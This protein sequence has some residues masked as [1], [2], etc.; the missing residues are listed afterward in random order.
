MSS[1]QHLYTTRLRIE[2]LRQSHATVVFPAQQDPSIYQYIPENALSLEEL[3]R[4]YDFLEKAT[5]PDGTEHW[6]NWIVFLKDTDIVIGTFQATIPADGDASIAYIVFPAFWKRGYATEI[7]NHMLSHIFK[8]YNPST[9][10]AEIDTRNLASLQL[11]QR[12]GF[13]KVKTTKNADFFKGSSSDEFTYAITS[14]EWYHS[15][16]SHHDQNLG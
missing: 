5:S 11:V 1:D 3:T 4:R 12:W 10:I 14:S 7:G 6:L 16:C 13:A 15:E 8:T 2:A 9:I